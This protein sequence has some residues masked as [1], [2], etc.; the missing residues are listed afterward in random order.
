MP[1]E[2][3]C[4]GH[5]TDLVSRAVDIWL[6][7]GRCGLCTGYAVQHAALLKRLVTGAKV[8]AIK[9]PFEFW[10]AGELASDSSDSI[11]HSQHHLL[12]ECV[13]GLLPLLQ[14]LMRTLWFC[15]PLRR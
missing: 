5:K 12:C 15:L 4:C 14:R 9:Q 2:Q 3:A 8:R 7:A 6:C 13:P 10:R 1:V 11:S